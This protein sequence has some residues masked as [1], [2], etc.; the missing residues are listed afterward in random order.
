MVVNVSFPSNLLFMEL[1]G[2]IIFGDPDTEVDVP[3]SSISWPEWIKQEINPLCAKCLKCR[4][5]LVCKHCSK[6]PILRP[7]NKLK[8]RRLVL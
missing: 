3:G 7:S 8:D 2:A 6:N 1:F 5:E 4:Q